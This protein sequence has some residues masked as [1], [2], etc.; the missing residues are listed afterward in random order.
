MSGNA[1]TLS[2]DYRLAEIWRRDLLSEKVRREGVKG[3][4]LTGWNQIDKQVYYFSSSGKLQTGWQKIGSR[5]FYFKATGT[6]GVRGKM[7]TGWV[8]IGGNKYYFKR[9]GEFGTK[10]MRFQGGYK[11]I[12]GKRYYFDSNGV[13]RENPDNDGYV[14]DP[15]TGVR[16]RRIPVLYRPADWKWLQSGDR[17]GIYGGAA[18]HGGRDQGLEGRLWLR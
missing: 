17:R 8:T 15:V 7:F 16:Y 10:G 4:R 11:T 9:T 3:R 12:D 1:G 14:T 5:T 2:N 6:Y 13:Y 18:V